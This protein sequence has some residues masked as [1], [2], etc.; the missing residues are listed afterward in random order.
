MWIQ[1]VSLTNFRSYASGSIKLSKGINLIVGQNNSGKSTL[2]KSVAWLQLGFPISAQDIRKLEQRGKVELILQGT[3]NYFNPT[4]GATI[5]I[6]INISNQN[7]LVESRGRQMPLSHSFLPSYD[8]N[9]FSSEY[10][11]P[12]PNQEPSNFIYP[13]LSK[14]KV[15]N[16]EESINLQ[17]TN[18]VSGNFTF[19][20]AKVDRLCDSE[21][22]EHTE[23]TE[24]CN[25]IIGF[26]MSAASSGN[27]KKVAKTIDVHRG[28]DTGI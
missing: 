21:I 10:P 7:M 13:Y 5:T 27:G 15:M 2:L 8:S 12:I 28:S 26:R 20:S 11:Y 4:P 1:K 18:S 6:S 14:R 25:E 23:F 3:K 19:L 24:Y 17:A 22:P 16:F 9:A